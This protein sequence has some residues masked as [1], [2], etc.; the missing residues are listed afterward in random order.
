[1]QAQTQKQTLIQNKYNSHPCT[2]TTTVQLTERPFF[3]MSFFLL[4]VSNSN[5]GSNR[6][7]GQTKAQTLVL[8]LSHG[9]AQELDC[10]EVGKHEKKW[11]QLVVVSSHSVFLLFGLFLVVVNMTFAHS[12]WIKRM[13][14]FMLCMANRTNN[15]HKSITTTTFSFPGFL[16]SFL[17]YEQWDVVVDVVYLTKRER[18]L[19]LL[20]I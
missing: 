4:F 17:M 2:T 6:V 1:M 20:I 15:V 13:M 7:I 8:A 5:N 11:L 14:V 12:G 19:T 3:R 9:L 10:L 18:T 16:M